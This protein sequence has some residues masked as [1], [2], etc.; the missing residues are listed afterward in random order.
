MKCEDSEVIA[1]SVWI[2]HFVYHKYL[3]MYWV[4][5]L[6]STCLFTRIIR[7]HL[8]RLLRTLH[9][10]VDW[11]LLKITD[12]LGSAITS[13]TVMI[14]SSGSCVSVA[15]SFCVIHPHKKQ[16]VDSDRKKCRG[17]RLGPQGRSMNP[18]C[19]KWGGALLSWYRMVSQ[20]LRNM[21]SIKVKCP[22]RK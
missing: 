11:N 9:S 8:L 1:F 19:T 22:S 13:V 10:D 21:F 3:I 16:I 2:L 15:Q 17:S 12:S 7:S 20:T 6:I 18:P 5:A 14:N 4:I